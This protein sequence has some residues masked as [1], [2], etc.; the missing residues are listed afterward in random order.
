MSG[1]ELVQLIRHSEQDASCEK[2]LILW[3][4]DTDVEE[5]GADLMWAKNVSLQDIKEHSKIF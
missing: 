4:A 1:S 5:C 2:I 3:T